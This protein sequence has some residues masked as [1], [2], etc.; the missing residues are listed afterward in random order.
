MYVSRCKQ[1]VPGLTQRG[2]VGAIPSLTGL[3]GRGSIPSLTGLRGRGSEQGSVP[4]HYPAVVQA[5]SLT[6]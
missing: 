6:L 2:A 3:R 1:P 4:S 5:Q